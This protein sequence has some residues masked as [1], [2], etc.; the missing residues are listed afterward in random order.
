MPTLRA[1]PDCGLPRRDLRQRCPAC[2][3]ITGASRIGR[4]GSTR[5]HRRRRAQLI[6]QRAASP[7]GLRCDECD[8][9]LSGGRDTHADHRVALANGGADAASNLA[10]LCDRCNLRKGAR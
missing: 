2:G 4:N 5:A 7:Q 1:C 6:D 3:H 10:V 8:R 9:P